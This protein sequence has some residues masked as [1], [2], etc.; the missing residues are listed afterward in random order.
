MKKSSFLGSPKETTVITQGPGI[1]VNPFLRSFW[2]IPGTC[3]PR[4]LESRD[5]RELGRF[6]FDCKERKKFIQIVAIVN[7][8]W[9]GGVVEEF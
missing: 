3:S 8:N 5:R 1:E 2:T 9:K 4:E 6:D 7:N